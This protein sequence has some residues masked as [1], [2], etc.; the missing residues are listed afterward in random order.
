MLSKLFGPSVMY[1]IRIWPPSFPAHLSC[2]EL[3]SG[4][5]I[6]AEAALLGHCPSQGFGKIHH[7]VK[8]CRRRTSKKLVLHA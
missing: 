4:Q 1:E 3:P 7:P 6:P 5:I 2:V 8:G